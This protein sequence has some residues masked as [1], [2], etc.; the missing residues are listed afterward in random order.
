MRKSIRKIV[1]AV[2]A[3]TMAFTSVAVSNV[4]IA[5]AAGQTFIPT[6]AVAADGTVYSDANVDVVAS[7]DLK[8][9]A[10]DPT[11][12]VD[13]GTVYSAKL[14][15]NGKNTTLDVS[16]GQGGKSYR[17]AFK[18]TA[19]N[20]CD[21]AVDGKASQGKKL[22]ILKDVAITGTDSKGNPSGTAAVVTLADNSNGTASIYPTLSTSLKAGETVWYAGFG[23]NP[24]IYS[25]TVNG[26]GGAE[27]TTEATTET[28]TVAPTTE[29]TT[30]TTTVAPA[31]E[32]TE[33][34]TVAPSP[35]G[36]TRVVTLDGVNEIK[37]MFTGVYTGEVT[38]EME[39]DV[40]SINGAGSIIRLR[41]SDGFDHEAA[42]RTIKNN[43][44]VDGTVVLGKS[45]GASS[46]TAGTVVVGK[47]TIKMTLNT[48]TGAITCTVNGVE[49]SREDA[50]EYIG[51]DV[52]GIKFGTKLTGTANVKVTAAGGSNVTTTE[53]TTETTTVTTTETTT[54]TTTVAP[55]TTE[56]TTAATTETTTESTT[57]VP[58]PSD[59]V[60][61]AVGGA[62]VKVGETV[63]VPVT[64]TG[65]KGFNNYTMFVSYDPAVVSIEDVADGDITLEVGGVTYKASNAA[66]IKAQLTNVPAKGNSDFP[67]ADGKL[68][69]AEL[70]RIKVAF[71]IDGNAVEGTSLK[72]FTNDGTL[73][74]LKVKGVAAGKADIKVEVV[75]DQFNVVS[76]DASIVGA[77]AVESTAGTVEVEAGQTVM[78]E[79]HENIPMTGTDEVKYQLD[80]K[81]T[82]KVTVEM[83]VQ[84]DQITG[85]GSIYRLRS[86]DGFD[87]E[88]ALRLI[89]NA[90]GVVDG[91]VV[92]GKSEG[93]SSPAAGTLVAPGA[94]NIKFVIDTETGD[95]EC[96]VNGFVS[97]RTN[98][99]AYIGKDINQIKI[100][101][102]GVGTITRVFV[103]NATDGGDD[104]TTT[105]ETTT[106][107]TT[108]SESTESTTA[109]PTGFAFGNGKVEV[110]ASA[111]DQS[112][113]LPLTV[114]NNPG[115]DSFAFFIEYDPANIELVGAA[116][117]DSA[118]AAM[119][120]S[121]IAY[122]PSAQNPDYAGLADGVKTTAQIGKVKVANAGD[123][124]TADGAYI[125]LVFNVKAN[126]PAGTYTVKTVST[127]GQYGFYTA[128]APLNVT[129]MDNTIVV[130]SGSVVTT[131]TESTS[132]ST[133][134]ATESSSETTTA[135]TTTTTETS[136][137]TTTAV[138]ES[139]SETTTRKT[140]G[141]GS[142][143]SVIKTTT[144]TTTEAT[145][146]EDTTEATT[147][148]PKDE[149]EVVIDDN[150]NISII[151]PDGNK[152]TVNVPKDTVVSDVDFKDL[153][154]YGWAKDAV[155]KLASLGIVTGTADDMYAPALPCKRAD[156]AIL[157]NRT[158]GLE[159]AM[160]KNFD[161][162]TNPEKYYYSD[163][164]MGYSAGILSGYGDN[165]FKPEQYCTREEMFVLV[166]KTL[167]Y[168]GVDVTSTSES[169]L[170]KY[171]DKADI[172]WWAAPYAAFLTDAGI[173]TGSNGNAEPDRYINRAEMAVM[174]Y[175]DYE[176][177]VAY[178][179]ELG[180]KAAADK[181]EE[182][183]TE[184]TTVEET[185]TE[186]T[187]AEEE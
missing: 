124:V 91:S 148:S 96:I 16:D 5:V 8:F 108:V 128:A 163:V 32:T 125:T 85:A 10:L 172:A 59:K 180:M 66:D 61:V 23:T 83:D 101:T 164:R 40:A 25:I 170:D 150:G 43:G 58:S 187:T 74:T 29:A 18:I 84:L 55:T 112:V 146:V 144:T 49:S 174:M 38:V 77:T 106:E 41:S 76:S 120:Q 100:G 105:T 95:I 159:T 158:L 179:N 94:N 67:G 87:H 45:E 4:S 30:E 181:A 135:T 44:T 129:M 13:N 143:G 73:F 69:Q 178:L 20:D 62:K 64:V 140:S 97:S 37:D 152:V 149:N 47:N 92:L 70:G 80:N 39:I 184:A 82:G 2:L 86:S 15:T 183:T 12:T 116:S 151:T 60:A 9:A 118:V 161:D 7:Q 56:S 27:T 173:I 139:S 71:V 31:T 42:L 154:N 175:K 102:K 110:S 14:A 6:A 57:V 98:D 167:E 115:F 78:S 113:N 121:Q 119:I 147:S 156:F 132:E 111:A 130:K 28:T 136:S 153:D 11:V 3:A 155:N 126:A 166:A 165:T 141:G 48:E 79:T 81:Y 22:A 160:T 169:V 54:V 142:S 186:T 185:S 99:P 182:T 24:D 1:S 33:A 114:Y 127:E 107:T 46:P 50:A 157:I 34:T 88:A 68:T 65:N 138:T 53:T 122:V 177:T 35:S 168:L 52:A 104:T 51:K 176:Y 72:A 137:E 162:N 109:A 133:T 63:D 90:D 17:L 93:A 145:T 171:A 75:N 117:S 123:T 89:K 21:V 36:E 26:A 131:T 19:K 134:A 103:T